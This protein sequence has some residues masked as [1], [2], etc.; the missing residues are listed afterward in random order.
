MC[1]DSS[2]RI[3]GHWRLAPQG[4]EGL[5]SG[6]VELAWVGL[7]LG[8]KRGKHCRLIKALKALKSLG[9][10][11]STFS[12]S[13]AFLICSLSLSLSLRCRT[14]SLSRC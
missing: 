5:E 11:F 8:G 9:L 12:S 6:W 3:V 7:P 2:A 10:A 1:W 13:V 14:M 4:D